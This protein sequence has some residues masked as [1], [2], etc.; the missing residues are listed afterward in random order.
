MSADATAQGL[1][2]GHFESLPARGYVELPAVAVQCGDKLLGF[3]KLTV[4]LAV[5][6]ADMRLKPAKDQS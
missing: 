1:L 2:Q 4:A 3:P 6:L 5:A